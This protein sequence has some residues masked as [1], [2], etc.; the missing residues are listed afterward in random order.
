MVKLKSCACIRN[1]LAGF[2]VHLDNFDI[3]F[4]VCVVGKIAVNRA[5]LCDIH[6]KIGKQFASVPALD[7]V[8]GVNAVRQVFCLCKAVFVTDEI[9]A[10]GFLCVSIGAGFFKVH[11]KF[12]PH[13]GS[14]KLRFAVVRMLN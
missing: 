10:L 11:L 12:R 9:I 6:I 4:K 3:R 8:D 7:L 5:V 14:F 13:F 2:S 1:H